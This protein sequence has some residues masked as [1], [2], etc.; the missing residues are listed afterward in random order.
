MNHST[1]SKQ[2]PTSPQAEEEEEE[3]EEEDEDHD[4]NVLGSSNVVL[5]DVRCSF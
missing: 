2:N 4:E 3:E 5:Y 1:I